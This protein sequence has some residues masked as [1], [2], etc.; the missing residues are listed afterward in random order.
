LKGRGKGL[1]TKRFSQRTTPRKGF[2]KKRKVISIEFRSMAKA[3]Q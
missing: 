1:D 2:K 3:N